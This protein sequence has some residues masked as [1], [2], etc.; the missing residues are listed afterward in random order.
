[1]IIAAK[2]CHCTM[3]SM[4]S[5][6]ISYASAAADR[7]K[8]AIERCN[9]LPGQRYEGDRKD[10]ARRHLVV[11]VFLNKNE[12]LGGECSADRDHHPAARLQ[13]ANQ[14][15]RNVAGRSG[16]DDCVVGPMV[17]PALVSI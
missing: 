5:R 3:D 2:C 7:R 4:R 12:L 16:N 1:M 8:I 10:L 15:R 17:D 14:G 11:A 9:L 6:R 13:L